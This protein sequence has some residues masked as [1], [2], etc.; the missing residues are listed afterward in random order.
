MRVAVGGKHL[1]DIAVSRGNELEHGNV[2]RAAAEIV[3]GDFAALLLVQAVGKCRSSRLVD[4][5]KNFQTGDFACVFGG[6]PLGIIE[7]GRHGDDGAVDRF[8]E[9]VFSPFFQL[10]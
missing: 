8:A 9:I 1:E 6:L 2:K 3:D 4:E 10:A 7:I 5:A